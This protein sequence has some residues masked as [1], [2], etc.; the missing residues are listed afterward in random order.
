MFFEGEM[1]TLFETPNT[2]EILFSDKPLPLSEEI[3]KVPV[4][5]F[6]KFIATRRGIDSFLYTE[7]LQVP[8]WVEVDSSHFL[9]FQNLNP[10]E[11]LVV[12]DMGETGLG[13]FTK[14]RI[15]EGEIV[16]IYAGSVDIEDKQDPYAMT[17]FSPQYYRGR[18]NEIMEK[19]IDQ[20]DGIINLIYSA[21]KVGGL[22]SFMQSLPSPQRLMDHDGIFCE[23]IAAANLN[24]ETEFYFLDNEK[25]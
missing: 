23:S 24:Q 17:C 1:K 5:E 9:K 12:C 8:D 20:R 2:K 25:K 14:D 15:E 10:S 21:N 7:S 3:V 18:L 19:P 6:Q 22:A 4:E 11:K 13:L 16:A